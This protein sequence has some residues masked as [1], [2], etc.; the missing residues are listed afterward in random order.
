MWQEEIASVEQIN[1]L[2]FVWL[3]AA[4]I[5]RLI[6]LKETKYLRKSYNFIVIDFVV[7]NLFYIVNSVYYA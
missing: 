2:D 7:I 6:G 5:V 3:V 4:R 1:Y